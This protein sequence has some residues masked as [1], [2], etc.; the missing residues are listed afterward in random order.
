MRQNG[1]HSI[2][3]KL[4]ER[5]PHA[6]VVLMAVFPRGQWP[7]PSRDAIA[8]LNARLKKMAESEPQRMHWLDINGK[9]LAANGE[10]PKEIMPD[11]LHLSPAG[12]KIWSEGLAGV[13][14]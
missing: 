10:L 1:V 14:K 2:L 9:F 3:G 12:Y 5:L 11:F 6:Q 13:V 7:N 4:R 8:S